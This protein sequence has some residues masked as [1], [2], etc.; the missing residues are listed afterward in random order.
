MRQP[1]NERRIG[2]RVWTTLACIAIVFASVLPVAAA[3]RK[4]PLPTTPTDCGRKSTIVYDG[5]FGH[6]LATTS[7][8][9]KVVIGLEAVAYQYQRTIKI[10]GCF[11][12]MDDLL[13]LII[14]AAPEY[15]LSSQDGFVDVMPKQ[16]ANSK[17]LD[18]VV[19]EFELSNTDWSGATQLLENVIAANSQSTK[20]PMTGDPVSPSQNAAIPVV[21]FSVNLK[22]VTVRRALHEITKKSGN[23]FWAFQIT[24]TGRS[25]VV[26]NLMY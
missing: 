15:Q 25:F 14:D 11:E 19:P 6:L 22:D 2:A 3:Q 18:S 26:K 23:T 24:G 16:S 10:S 20:F 12:T 9:Y 1:S 13:K 4:R 7:D 17:L 21:Y 8:H 5:D